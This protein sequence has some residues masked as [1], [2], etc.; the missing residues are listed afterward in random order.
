MNEGGKQTESAQRG[1]GGW[2]KAAQNAPLKVGLAVAAASAAVIV[3]LSIVLVSTVW[4]LS[5]VASTPI[6]G[7]GG[8]RHRDIDR[9]QERV[10]NLGQVVPAMVA[11]AAL[12]ILVVSVVAWW[13]TR[14]ANE[15]MEQALAIQQA[16]VADASHELRTPL[17]TLNS[18]IQLAQHRLRRGGDIDQALS[19]LRR[20]ADV[21]DEVL[22]DLLTAAEMAGGPT[23]N[24]RADVPMTISAALRITAAKADEGGVELTSSCPAGL[25][26]RAD[27]TAVVRA[28]VALVDNAIHH[29]ARGG[30]VAVRA[31]SNHSGGREWVEIRVVDEG[32][33]IS[34]PN[35]DR[36]FERFA[37]EDG[38]SRGFG[39]GLALVRDI[40]RRFDGTVTVESTSPHGT[41][42]LLRL[43]AA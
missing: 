4:R 31:T 7:S 18:R 29:T 43:P 11:L 12:S 32:T 16:F 10:V 28:I 25:V 1:R 38:S 36:L 17:T 19:D 30:M 26:V 8:S 27:Q 34:L 39:L 33:G 2:W 15:P 41:T 42:F 23:P 40:A 13:A 37:R 14:K 9:W 21:M 20:D 35:P 6:G 5:R 3:L 22:T 24:A